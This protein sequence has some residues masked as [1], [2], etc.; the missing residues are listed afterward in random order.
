MSTWGEYISGQPD[1]HLSADITAWREGHYPEDHDGTPN[2]SPTWFIVVFS[3]AV[4]GCCASAL[5]ALI[6]WLAG[7]FS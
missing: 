1:A 7:V 5:A 4:I 6:M 2:V 3:L